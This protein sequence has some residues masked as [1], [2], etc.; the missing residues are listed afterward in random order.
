[1]SFWIVPVSFSCGTPCSS[2]ATMK[3]A[4]TG[5]TAPFI[6]ML[7]DILIE[8]DSV[9]QEFHVLDRVDR[10]A[11][12]AD[13]AD[14]ARIV[15]VVATVGG[16]VEG[17]AQPLL[18]GREIAAIKGVGFLGRREAGVLADGPGPTGVHRRI[19]PTGE[20]SDA[21]VTAV[22]AF[23]VFG[24]VHRAEANFLNSLTRQIAAARLLLVQLFPTRSRR[25]IGHCAAP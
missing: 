9:E 11:R 1:M 5:S 19:R 2:P 20:R 17:D 13:V 15:A 24:I 6:V 16:E 25:L 10:H 14:D 12:H 22:Y 8:R 21:G 23:R 3:K 7:T 4:M 18:P